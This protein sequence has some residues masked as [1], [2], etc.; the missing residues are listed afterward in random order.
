MFESMNRC[1]L[2]HFVSTVEDIDIRDIIIEKLDA[3]E[4]RIKTLKEIFSKEQFP[5]PAGFSD[6]DVNLNA[7]KLFTDTFM[8]Q[9]LHFMSRMAIYDYNL[10]FSVSP[11]SDVRKVFS[12]SL[13]FYVQIQNKIM[14]ILLQKGLYV[15]S[16]YVPYPEQVD[17]VKEES[18]LD[19]LFGDKRPVH[20]IQITSLSLNIQRNILGHQILIAFDQVTKSQNIKAYFEKG[21]ELS[22]KFMDTFTSPLKDADL[23]PPSYG[24]IGITNSTIAPFSEK[25]ML[26]LIGALNTY[27]I[28]IYGYSLSNS[29]RNDLFAKYIKVLSETGDYALE[30]IKLLIKYGYFEEPPKLPN[31]SELAKV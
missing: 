17:F 22:K 6:Q 4:A 20:T 31:R 8:A 23:I 24:G 28:T 16:P 14:D 19:G 7:P 11:R 18:F 1:I 10:S 26:N 21:K 9:Y 5:V 27:A 29:A 25:L 12:D 3:K 15:R 30:G 13:S 2:K